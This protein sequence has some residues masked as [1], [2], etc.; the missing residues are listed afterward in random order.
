MSI[1]EV[2][3]TRLSKIESLLSEG[4]QLTRVGGFAIPKLI[5]SQG[6]RIRLFFGGPAG[7]SW[8][9]FFLVINLDV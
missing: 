4:H 5:N 7:F 3:Q 6:R 9:G 2:M 8:A 1:S